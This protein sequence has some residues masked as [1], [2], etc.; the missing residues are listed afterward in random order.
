MPGYSIQEWDEDEA[1]I[2]EYIMEQYEQTVAMELLYEDM[3]EHPLFYW[4][5]TCRRDNEV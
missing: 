3:K 4:K 1:E 2:E 5:I